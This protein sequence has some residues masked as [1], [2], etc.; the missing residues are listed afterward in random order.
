MSSS[1]TQ[2]VAV[3]ERTSPEAGEINHLELV[4]ALYRQGRSDTEIGD[5]M[6]IPVQTVNGLARAAGVMREPREAAQLANRRWAARERIA[7]LDIAA[8]A[9]R[10]LDEG[11]PA[12]PEDLAR[13]FDVPADLLWDALAEQLSHEPTISVNHAHGTEYAA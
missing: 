3:Y 4:V 9:E 1:G 11:N 12:E 7:R 10:W 2:H 6:E 5:L 8:L 13:E